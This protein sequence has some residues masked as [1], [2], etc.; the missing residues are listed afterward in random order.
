MTLN[1]TYQIICRYPNGCFIIIRMNSYQ[2]VFESA[3]KKQSNFAAA[4]DQHYC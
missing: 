2:L 4:I 3:V 1:D